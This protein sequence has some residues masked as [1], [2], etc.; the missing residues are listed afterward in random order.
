MSAKMFFKMQQLQMLAEKGLESS[1]YGVYEV[2]SR[3][4]E[5]AGRL[6]HVSWESE[7]RKRVIIGTIKSAGFHRSGSP[8]FFYVK[9]SVGIDNISIVET[10]P[11]FIRVFIKDPIHKKWE[12]VNGCKNIH[13]AAKIARSYD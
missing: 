1:G 13:E 5:F 11:N 12:G 4:N 2:T 8:N 7:P 3:R 6:C 10:A 9:H